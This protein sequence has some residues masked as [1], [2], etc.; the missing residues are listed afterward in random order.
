MI[1]EL[2]NKF[3]EDKLISK[4][5]YQSLSPLKKDYDKKLGN[6]L[7]DGGFINTKRFKNLFQMK[8]KT[9]FFKFLING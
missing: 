2:I 4:N 8:I 1:P 7:V 9:F 3:Y 6:F 5:Q